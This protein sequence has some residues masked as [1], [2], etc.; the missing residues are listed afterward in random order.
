MNLFDGEHHGRADILLRS[1]GIV[2]IND[3]GS[4]SVRGYKDEGIFQ[5]SSFSSSFFLKLRLLLQITVHT[6][7][8]LVDTFEIM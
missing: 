6:Y 5:N 8:Q 2:V 4:V 7:L 1:Y 3:R